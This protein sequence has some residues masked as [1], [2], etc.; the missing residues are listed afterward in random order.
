MLGAVWPSGPAPSP[1]N[2]MAGAWIPVSA[3]SWW[4]LCSPIAACFGLWLLYQLD[5]RRSGALIDGWGS[6]RPRL[7]RTDPRD[8]RRWRQATAPRR[9][10]TPARP[11]SLSEPGLTLCCCRPRPPSSPAIAT[12]AN[13]LQRHARRRADGLPRAARLIAQ[14][15]R[16]R[17]GQGAG[18]RRAPSARPQTPWVVHS[19][20]DMQAQTGDWRS[21]QEPPRYRRAPQGGRSDKGAARKALLLVERSR[22]PN[23]TQCRRCAGAGAR[24]VRPCAGAHRR[25]PAPGGSADQ[26]GGTASAR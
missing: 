9:R 1:P 23:A 5:R 11:T 3:S 12:A 10:S 2:G 14:A 26:A 19:L 13:R 16:R 4:R 15:L 6:R 18:L 17:P 7:S 25:D 21:A 24:G 22:A 8:R 20:F